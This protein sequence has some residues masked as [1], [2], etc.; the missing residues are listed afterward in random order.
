MKR[1][2]TVF[3]EYEGRVFDPAY[4]SWEP[5]G[6]SLAGVGLCDRLKQLLIAHLDRRLDGAFLAD[7]GLYHYRQGWRDTF[8]ELR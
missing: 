6:R 3:C 8:E 1:P 2:V 7:G 4:L 5:H